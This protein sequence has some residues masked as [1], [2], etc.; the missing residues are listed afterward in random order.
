MPLSGLG[1]LLFGPEAARHLFKAIGM[2]RRSGGR[3]D[4]VLLAHVLLDYLL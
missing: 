4:G 3:D 1:G 2:D